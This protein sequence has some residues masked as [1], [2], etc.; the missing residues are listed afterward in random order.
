MASLVPRPIY[1]TAA[2]GLH[3]RYVKSGSG[4]V[5][6]TFLSSFPRMLGNQSDSRYAIIAYLCYNRAINK[7]L[8]TQM[9]WAIESACIRLGYLKFNEEQLRSVVHVLSGRNVSVSFP[10]GYGPTASRYV[11]P[12]YRWLSMN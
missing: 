8:P 4:K 11:T 7:Q 9:E 12:F 5:L 6:Y 2:D 1:F 3:H 10:M